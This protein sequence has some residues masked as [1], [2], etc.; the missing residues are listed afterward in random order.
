MTCTAIVESFLGNVFIHIYIVCGLTQ[1]LLVF[2]DNHYSTW[3]FFFI[4]ASYQADSLAM[5]TVSK[6]SELR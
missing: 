1:K 4:F 5:D 6:T 3:C 2:P